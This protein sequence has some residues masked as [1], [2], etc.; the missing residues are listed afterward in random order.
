MKSTVASVATWS[1][2][3]H[4]LTFVMNV[5]FADFTFDSLS[6]VTSQHLVTHVTR[7]GQSVCCLQEHMTA[8]SLSLTTT[9]SPALQLGA[10][11]PDG[12]HPGGGV[13]SRG[14]LSSR[15]RGAGGV[16]FATLNPG[17]HVISSNTRLSYCPTYL[18]S[19]SNVGSC[20][21]GCVVGPFSFSAFT[22]Y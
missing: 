12:G 7:C 17:L 6:G 5:Y 10:E 19:P 16:T 2:S 13:A 21:G 18:S 4:Y 22:V 1:V 3:H 15:H 9:S 8:I 11:T 20:C 14:L